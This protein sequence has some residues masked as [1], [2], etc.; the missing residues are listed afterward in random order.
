MKIKHLI[1]LFLCF[2]MLFGAMGAL[3]SCGDNTNGN[4][5]PDNGTT[6]P[7]DNEGGNNDTGVN[8]TVT[9]KD[10][11]DNAIK[12][13]KVVFISGDYTS[14]EATTDASGNA[15]ASVKVNGDVKVSFVNL[16]GYGEPSA[17]KST[18]DSGKTALEIVRA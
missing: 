8:Y 9:L 3:T 6:P 15:T 1:A 11:K 10:Y 14:S 2:A 12:D 4:D 5:N 7:D 17:K 16:E 13:I 18:F